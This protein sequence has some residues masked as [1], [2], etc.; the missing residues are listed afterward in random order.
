MILTVNSDYNYLIFI[1]EKLFVLFEVRVA[2]RI[3]FSSASFTET[4]YQKDKQ[5]LPGNPYSR[6]FICIPR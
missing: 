6:K 5:A 2:E 3:T 1:K 4:V